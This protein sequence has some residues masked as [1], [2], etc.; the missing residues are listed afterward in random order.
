VKEAAIK[1][2][3]LDPSLAWPHMS[4][5]AV[6]FWNDWDWSAAE[7]E[8]KQAIALNP[9]FAEAHYGYS[10]YLVAMERL[11]E[12]VNECERARDLDPFDLAVN[13]W[14]GQAL[15]QARRYDD[16][17]R[18]LRRTL[19]MFPD[20]GRFYWQIADVYEQKKMFAEAYAARQ[21]ALTLKKDPN[22][23]ALAEAY[24][25]AGYRGYL[26][27]Q[28][29]ILE[30]APHSPFPFPFLAHLYAM[31]DDAAHA[32]TYLERSYE[33]HSEA[34]P[35]IRT[36]PELDSIRSSPRYSD[37]V[38]RIGFPQPSSDKNLIQTRTAL[39]T[40]LGDLCTFRS[41]SCRGCA[42]N[43]V[44]NPAPALTFKPLGAAAPSSCGN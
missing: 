40:T 23:T 5:A 7:A 4:L 17:L 35:F 25:R 34:M 26:L 1:A 44:S 16:A 38:S 21:Q 39:G 18:Q 14:L 9:N 42:S 3:A 19:E 27:K 22:V 8:I 43:K 15:Y 29:Q 28:I 30:Q 33:E 41:F 32:V 12:A 13:E 20:R 2:L 31:L 37:L 11:D 24:K 36:T 6:K 10:I